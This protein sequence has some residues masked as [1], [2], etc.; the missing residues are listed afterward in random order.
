M[1]KKLHR[2]EVFFAIGLWL[3]A[4]GSIMKK[5]GFLFVEAASSQRPIASSQ[6]LNN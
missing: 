2:D 5:Y 4:S 1:R 3:L 6:Q